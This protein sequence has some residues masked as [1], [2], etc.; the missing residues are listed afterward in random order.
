MDW[1]LRAGCKVNLYLDIVGIREDGYHELESLFV[2]LP[3]PHDSLR[4]EI[5]G[6][7]LQLSCS[8]PGLISE[9]NILCAAYRAFAG[10]TG[11]APGLRLH[12]EKGIPMGAGLGGGSSDAAVFLNW[13]NG[14]A[15]DCR[16]EERDLQALA[17][18]LGADVPFFLTNRPAWVTG[19]GEKLEAAAVDFGSLTVV[20]V[21]PKVHVNTLW[22]Y[23]RWDEMFRSGQIQSKKMLTG[24]SSPIRYL[25][26]TNLDCVWNCFEALVFQEFPILQELKQC[27]LGCGAEACVMSGSGSSLVGFF[28]SMAHALRCADELRRAGC[29]CQGVRSGQVVI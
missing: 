18:T 11:Y 6:S 27:I 29:M 15:G 28:D 1:E 16:L 7:G 2:P 21:C 14:Q 22:A 20:V 3:V 17:L 25:S 8:D 9:S 12:L 5:G 4:I 19:I 24:I 23:A 13:L 10:A 26:F